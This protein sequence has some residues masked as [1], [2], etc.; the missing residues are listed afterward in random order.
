MTRATVASYM[1]PRPITFTP[2]TEVSR[3]VAQLLKA[4]ISGAPVVD[5]TGAIVGVFT[6]K[7]C[8]RALLHASYHKQLGGRVA[9][10]MSRDVVTLDADLDILSAA[11]AFLD[12]SFR[13][14]PVVRDGALVGVISR[15][16][17]L[18]AFTAEW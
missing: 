10:F 18:R 13:R 3:A 8:F 5:D 6:A 11:E 15:L 7:D 16:D 17:L 9:E 12:A 2:E 14:F 1:T 4:N